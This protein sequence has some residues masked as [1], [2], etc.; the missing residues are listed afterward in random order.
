MLIENAPQSVRS[1]DLK[2]ENLNPSRRR[3]HPILPT[4]T[5]AESEHH[6]RRLT[7]RA[8]AARS[9]VTHSPRGAGLPIIYADEQGHVTSSVGGAGLGLGGARDI[10]IGCMEEVVS[11]QLLSS[12]WLVS[13]EATMSSPELQPLPAAAFSSLGGHPPTP[14]ALQEMLA[15]NK[16]LEGRSTQLP[17]LSLPSSAA[18]RPS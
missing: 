8:A 16:F 4:H 15:R 7:H 1:R 9:A 5:H 3:S 12:P 13:C 2:L 11:K 14:A 18:T 6:H 17:G 10:K